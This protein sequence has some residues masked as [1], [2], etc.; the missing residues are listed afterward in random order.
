[1]TKSVLIGVI[2][3]GQC[4]EPTRRLA[5]Q[6]GGNIAK[7][8]WGLICGGLGGVMEGACHGAWDAGGLTIGILPGDTPDTANP[9][10]ALPIATGMGIARNV[11]I[12]RSARAVIA[13]SGRYGTLSEI[14][15]CLQ[16]GVPVISLQSHL[17]APDIIRVESA[18]DAVKQAA[19]FMDA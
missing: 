13:V 9:Y 12:V 1:M 15:Y 3:S 11:I 8:G 6:V 16:L 7:A 4:D 14:A 19:K 5:Y 10:V 17:V 2:G 18:E